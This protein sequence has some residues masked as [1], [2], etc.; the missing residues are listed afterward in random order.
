M[1]AERKERF[2]AQTWLKVPA[3]ICAVWLAILFSTAPWPL[4]IASL[5]PAALAHCTVFYLS[6]RHPDALR[7]AGGFLVGLFLDVLTGTIF[8]L[9]TLTCIAMHFMAS[10][11]RRF[12]APRG[13][14]HSWIGLAIASCAIAPVSWSI[15][16]LYAFSFQPWTPTLAQLALTAAIFPIVVLITEVIVVSLSVGE[17]NS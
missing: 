13:I 6:L 16:S 3:T 10:T 5:A 11:Q 15:A 1:M 9:G 2:P 4:A 7:P 12:L 17:K 8:G 14:I